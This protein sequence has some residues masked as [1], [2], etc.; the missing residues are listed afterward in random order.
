MKDPSSSQALALGLF[1]AYAIVGQ[2]AFRC[3]RV[4][5]GLLLLAK[6]TAAGHPQLFSNIMPGRFISAMWLKRLLWLACAFFAWRAW[7]WYGVG[8]LLLYGLVLGTWVDKLSPWPSYSRLL[9]LVKDRVQS[10]A[11]GFEAMFLLSTIRHVEGQLTAGVPFEK[12][13]TGVWLG[14]AVEAAERANLRDATKI[15]TTA[16]TSG[17]LANRVNNLLSSYVVIHDDILK[18]SV[19]K[20]VP[21]PGVFKEIDYCTHE[22]R[23]ASIAKEL[24]ECGSYSVAATP[25]NPAQEAFLEV[26]SEY[27][28]VLKATVDKLQLICHQLCRKSLGDRSY[29]MEIYSRDMAEYNTLVQAYISKGNEL[30]SLWRAAHS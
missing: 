6:D 18:P 7:R 1:I 20:V 14:R 19:R 2:W 11:A 25:E 9:K 17:E 10:G 8:P 22:D 26:L 16:S 27:I 3:Q 29:T 13:T 4:A 12:A 23:L 21:A 28:T 30:N 15:S 24:A 5:R